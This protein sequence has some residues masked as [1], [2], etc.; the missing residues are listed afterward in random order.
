MKPKPCFG[1]LLYGYGSSFFFTIL[2]ILFL[3]LWS[4]IYE[5]IL[6][7]NLVLSPGST[8]YGI[9]EKTPIP[10][11]LK[12]F[13]FNWT[14]SHEINNNNTKP[15]FQQIGP[16]TYTETKEKVSVI[17]NANNTV[18]YKHLKRW[19]FDPSQ[20]NGSLSDTFVSINPVGLVSILWFLFL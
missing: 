4:V 20:S 3:S 9:W 16:Y 8:T 2:G 15:R 6:R 11:T 14:N 19:W 7:N 12:L 10:V 13:L 17:W 1:V 18:T 5:A